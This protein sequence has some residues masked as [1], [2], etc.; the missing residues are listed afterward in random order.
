MKLTG[1]MGELKKNKALFFMILP[2]VIYFFIFAYIPMAGIVVAF[3]NYTYQGGLFL[4]PWCG[5]DNFRFFFNSGQ[6]WTVT[7]NTFL[8]NIVFMLT[9]NFFQI[10]VAI[11]LVEMAGKHLKKLCQSERNYM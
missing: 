8:Y 9:C 2:A 5:L 6:A 7:K 3:K 1:F 10:L 11:L 4:S